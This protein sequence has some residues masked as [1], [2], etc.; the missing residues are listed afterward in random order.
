MKKLE[1]ATPARQS[2]MYSHAMNDVVIAVSVL[3][4]VTMMSGHSF[5]LSYPLAILRHITQVPMKG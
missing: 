5:S 1:P 2:T 4:I 3:P